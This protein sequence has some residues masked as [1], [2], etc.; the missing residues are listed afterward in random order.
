MKLKLERYNL[1]EQYTE[2]KLYIND[3]F[4]CYTL[5]DKA[6]DLNKDG[7]LLDEGEGKVWGQTAIPYGT[8]TVLLTHSPKFKT[9]LPL[10]LNVKHFKGIRIH[11]GNDPIHTHGCILLAETVKNGKGYRSKIKVN[12]LV[13]KMKASKQEEFEIEIV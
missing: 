7:D 3:K 5:E 11:A 8:Y 2:G 9:L 12:E 1:T 6:R 13:Q 4:F 10:L